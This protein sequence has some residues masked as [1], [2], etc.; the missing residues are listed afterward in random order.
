MGESLPL[1]Y[2]EIV[3]G[4]PRPGPRL[5]APIWERDAR[6]RLPTGLLV[7]CLCGRDPILAGQL[8]EL[9]R[10]QSAQ[11]PEL[12]EDDFGYLVYLA[13]GSPA[14]RERLRRWRAEERDARVC[15][16]LDA[17]L[18]DRRRPAPG[19]RSFEEHEA[20]ARSLRWTDEAESFDAVEAL[21]ALARRDRARAARVA[22][23]MLAGGEPHP[24]A[25]PCVRSLLTFRQ[26]GELDR[27]L[28][29]M[30]LVSE[31]SAPATDVVD[32]LEA[33]DRVVAIEDGDRAE[34]LAVAFALAAGDE[35]MD[36]G[37]EEIHP[38]NPRHAKVCDLFGPG[39]EAKDTSI[40]A[41][42]EAERSSY[43]AFEA[44]YPDVPSLALVNELLR[45]RSAP[46]RL[47]CLLSWRSRAV[48]GSERGLRAAAEQQ[49]LVF[50]PSEL[51]ERL[52]RELWEKLGDELGFDFLG[53]S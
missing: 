7:Q 9:V 2:A 13:A 48:A 29:D 6:A 46:R 49:L 17:R 12:V 27:W 1:T 44:R 34:D 43:V 45:R 14:G 32:A 26:P 4:P 18:E 36:V 42:H 40:L 10:Y 52:K 38:G 30:G 11:Q 31:A 8:I 47:A 50:D 33:E 53:D 37:F 5:S 28:R 41:A 24:Y 20:F 39:T 25:L 23:E 19:P 35:L 3:E 21:R 22:E 51:A 15:A 16:L